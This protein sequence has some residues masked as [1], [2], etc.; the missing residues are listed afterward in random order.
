MSYNKTYRF[1][2][3]YRNKSKV[4]NFRPIIMSMFGDV[5]RVTLMGNITNDP[6]LRYTPSGAAVLSF[7]LATNRR[8][9]KNE[10]WVDEPT[11]HNI[12]VWLSAEPLAQRIRKGTRVYIE[13]R[14]QTRSWDNQEGQK[15]YKTEIV[16]D[17]VTLIARYEG[18][19]D[20]AS[21]SNNEAP[22]PK[23]AKK[24]AKPSEDINATEESIDPDDLPF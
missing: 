18:A 11:Y 15:Q 24:S 19:N 16:A 3:L 1:K 8:F 13:G 6:D 2:F 9:K 12:V 21:K 7:G 5:N 17:N 23:L 14:I 22:K 20:E 4:L 10:E